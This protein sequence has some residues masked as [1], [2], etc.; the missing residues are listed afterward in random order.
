MSDLPPMDVAGRLNRAAAALTGAGC[1]ALLVTHLTNVRYLTGFTGSAGVLVI[2][3]GG[4]GMLVTDGRYEEQAVDQVAASGAPVRVAI[5]RSVDAQREQIVGHLDGTTT[6]GLEADHVSWSQQVQYASGWFPQA[7]LVATTAIVETLRGTKDPGEVAR[8]ERACGIADAALAETMLRLEDGLTELQLARSLDE[9]M[10]RP[11]R[12]G[13]G[14]T[15][16]RA[17]AC[18][19][20]ETSSSST[21]VPSSTA[22][23]PT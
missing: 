9:A 21:S 8:I 13:P 4:D 15:I 16:G 3:P 19:S 17:G 1:E 2:G 6:I 11:V 20:A 23:T 10:W 12:T 18:S 7:T 5:G 14:L 22:T